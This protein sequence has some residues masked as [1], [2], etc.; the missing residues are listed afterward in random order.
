[1]RR[2][3]ELLIC[4]SYNC[5]FAQSEDIKRSI[6]TIKADPTSYIY[7]EVTYANKDEAFEKAMEQLNIKIE[8]WVRSIFPDQEFSSVIAKK[9]DNYCQQLTLVRG[10]WYNAFV[11]VNKDDIYALLP[12]NAIMSSNK[13]AQFDTPSDDE[14]PNAKDDT[15]IVFMTELYKTST[16]LEAK[17][18]LNNIAYKKQYYY[19]SVRAIDGQ[20]IKKNN[21]ILLIFNRS[22]AICAVLK[23]DNPNSSII[24]LKTGLQDSLANYPGCNAIW[25]VK[26]Y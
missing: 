7:G 22:N 4:I 25:I 14:L 17:A 13:Q 21:A 3:I 9:I 24:N 26:S 15:D 16:I 6:N 1:M 20:F 18:L 12:I 23:I 11:Y 5:V 2:L 10:N 8:L 19:G